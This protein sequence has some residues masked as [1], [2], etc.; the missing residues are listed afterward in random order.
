MKAAD[1]KRELRKVIPAL[2]FTTQDGLGTNIGRGL[3]QAY[4]P[5]SEVKRFERAVIALGLTSYWPACSQNYCAI[6]YI[7]LEPKA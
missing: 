3:L 7:R 6:R 4:V 1:V 5:F 2:E